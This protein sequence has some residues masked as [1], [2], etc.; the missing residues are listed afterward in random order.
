MT[1]YARLTD[2]KSFGLNWLL[3]QEVQITSLPL[4]S[5]VNL[6]KFSILQY[7]FFSFLQCVFYGLK[8]EN[9]ASGSMQFTKMLLCQ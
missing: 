8:A 5:C 1:L 6:T 7:S 4:R 9:P 3:F 2:Y